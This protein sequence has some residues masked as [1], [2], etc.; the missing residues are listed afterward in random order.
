MS[1]RSV[2]PDAPLEE[3]EDSRTALPIN[4]LEGV[5][6]EVVEK[7]IEDTYGRVQISR[8]RQTIE[9][10]M[11][12]SHTKSAVINYLTAHFE[13]FH[14]FMACISTN[15]TDAATYLHGEMFS[16]DF[17]VYTP[18]QM[19]NHEN[20]VHLKT[21]GPASFLAVEV[22][23][24][25]EVNATGRGFDKVYRD[26]FPATGY[27]NTRIHEI[28]VIVISREQFDHRRQRTPCRVNGI[29]FLGPFIT[30]LVEVMLNSLFFTLPYAVHSDWFGLRGVMFTACAVLARG[31][32]AL[33]YNTPQAVA[34]RPNS[35]P[36]L[37]IC[38]RNQPVR[39]YPLQ[40]DQMLIL[41]R[42][43]LHWRAKPIAT[44]DFF[45]KMK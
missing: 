13:S 25:S 6:G 24:D 17:S 16:P 40:R 23:W 45:A 9:R 20:A 29:W 39:Y 10:D 27:N 38:I 19:Y 42:Q 7:Q 12:E 18:E 14:N 3:I 26:L 21:V 28:W 33:M 11:P 32:A 34:L 22:E 35:Y 37:A 41:P 43:C 5:P 1:F 44:N 31:L 4:V 36:Y 8:S 2:I 30:F 15:G